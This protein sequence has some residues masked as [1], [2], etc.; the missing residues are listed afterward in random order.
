MISS[1]SPVPLSQ[2]GEAQSFLKMAAI[3]IERSIVG[4]EE[5]SIP[6]SIYY[7]PSEL[8][9]M[10]QQ[11]LYWCMRKISYVLETYRTRKL[12]P[13]RGPAVV[14]RTR[15]VYQGGGQTNFC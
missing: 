3:K 7:R 1:S 13:Y 11:F 8:A 5:C 6:Q 14:P 15:V 4:E 9:T 2:Q 12:E 10:S